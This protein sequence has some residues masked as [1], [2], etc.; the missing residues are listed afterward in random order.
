MGKLFNSEI[1]KLSQAWKSAK[2]IVSELSVPKSTVYNVLKCLQE[3]GNIDRKPGG[4][5][6]VTQLIKAN[7]LRLK[8]K[9][10]LTPYKSSKKMT[11][12]MGM[13]DRALRRGLKCSGVKSRAKTKRFLLTEKL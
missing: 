12:E 2:E 4:G 7:L 3:R 13:D 11:K 1:V 9:V 8:R 10:R 6:P 5:K